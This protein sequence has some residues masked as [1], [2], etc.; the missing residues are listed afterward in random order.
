MWLGDRSLA[1]EMTSDDLAQVCEDNPTINTASGPVDVTEA[2]PILADYND[3]GLLDS[4]GGWLFNIWWQQ[5]RRRHVL[6]HPLRR[7]RAAD[8]AEHAQPEQP[9][10]DRGAR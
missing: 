7:Q 3:T 6:E 5:R 4:P 1:A 9:G 8:D 10:D 2:C